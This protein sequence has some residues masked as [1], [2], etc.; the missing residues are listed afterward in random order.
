MHNCTQ[1]SED[2]SVEQMIGCMKQRIVCTRCEPSTRAY[3]GVSAAAP[4]MP[5][6][7][8]H[9]ITTLRPQ[10]DMPETT[11]LSSAA[12]LPSSPVYQPPGANTVVDKMDCPM[13]LTKDPCS[14][15]PNPNTTTPNQKHPALLDKTLMPDTIYKYILPGYK[16]VST[17]LNSI[18]T[19][20]HHQPDIIDKNKDANR[21]KLEPKPT[22]YI[23]SN[24][25]H[26]IDIKATSGSSLHCNNMPNR[27]ASIEN[28][29]QRTPN[30]TLSLPT[31][32]PTTNHSAILTF[33]TIPHLPTVDNPRIPH[34]SSTQ[35][36][37]NHPATTTYDN[38]SATLQTDLQIS[39][40]ASS[41]KPIRYQHQSAK[42][43]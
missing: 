31:E 40:I 25:I 9:A 32:S 19:G 4:F 15:G 2:I 18:D 5:T 33:P 38:H 43:P 30:F 17:S 1:H 39:P 41:A 36:G 22:Q 13:Q 7:K 28:C 37:T 11:V 26:P 23:P 12:N 27:T 3:A 35:Y 14:A 34:T 21:N 42:L 20:S 8:P 29:A 24:R 16:M 6:T 10:N